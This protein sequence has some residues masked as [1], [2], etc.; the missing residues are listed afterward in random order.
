MKWHKRLYNF[1]MCASLSS[2][3]ATYRHHLLIDGQ[4]VSLDIMDTAGK[5]D[6]MF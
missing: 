5:V 3:E 2:S 4:F 1:N 6:S